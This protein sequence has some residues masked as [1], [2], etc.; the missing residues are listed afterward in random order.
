MLQ[1]MRLR[2]VRYDLATEQ[3]K[4]MRK[5]R[6]RVGVRK[7]SQKQALKEKY[8]KRKSVQNNDDNVP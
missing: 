1:S 7:T 6:I 2:R 5:V 4:H 8:D 3:Q